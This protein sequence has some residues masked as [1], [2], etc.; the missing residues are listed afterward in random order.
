VDLLSLFL[1]FLKASFLSFGGSQPLPLLQDE[2]ARQRG[3]LRDEDFATAIAIGRITPGPNGLF[4]LAVGYFVAGVPG[5]LV[6]TLAL[7]VVALSVLVLLRLH[8][9][10]EQ[11]RAVRD[12]V[13]GIQAGAIGLTFAVGYLIG[14]ATV[15]SPLDLAIAVGAFMLLTFTP[16]DAL[17]VIAG[18]AALG[19]LHL[20]L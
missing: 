4:T 15:R 2:L 19:L 9:R 20:A 6:A 17:W 14:G 7:C 5:L 11:V 18:A 10:L 16:L 1:V 13:R 3:L 8:A 12:G